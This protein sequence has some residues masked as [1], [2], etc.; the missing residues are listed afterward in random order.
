MDGK[1]F[2]P[3]SATWWSGAVLI[4]LGC[5]RAAAD[6]LGL[7]AVGQVIDQVT[8]GVGPSVMIAQSAGLIGL[9]AAI[10]TPRH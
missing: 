8:G 1:Y 5:A 10:A 7:G 3:R 6:S 9:R 4:L 2:K